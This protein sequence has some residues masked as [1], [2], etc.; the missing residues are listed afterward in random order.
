MSTTP[1]IN[2][3][4]VSTTLVINL[5]SVSMKI[6]M[7]LTLENRQFIRGVNN[8]GDTFTAGVDET[9]DKMMTL[10]VNICGH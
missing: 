1:E 5:L 3:R 7:L 4:P 10:D 9:G 2:E 8:T 6:S